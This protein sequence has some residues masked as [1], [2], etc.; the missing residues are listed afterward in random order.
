[1]ED[2]YP[3]EKIDNVCFKKTWTNCS[4][5]LLVWAV[6]VFFETDVRFQN[7]QQEMGLSFFREFHCHKKLM[8]TVIFAKPKDYLYHLHLGKSFTEFQLF[9]ASK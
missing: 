2:P 4:T 7:R 6:Q 5:L 1:M 8:E 3:V 9:F